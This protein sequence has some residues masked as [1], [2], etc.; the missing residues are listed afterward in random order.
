MTQSHWLTILIVFPFFSGCF[1]LFVPN[2]NNKT[3][4]WYAL[5]VSLVEFLLIIYTFCIHFDFSNPNL[6]LIEN[7]QWINKISFHWCLGVDG[8]S[9][10]LILLTGFITTLSILGSWPI[11]RN[12]RLFFF[13]ML[14]LYSGQIGVFAS[15]DLLLFFLMWEIELLPIYFLL[16]LWG[17]QKRLYAANKFIFY[18][19]LGSIFILIGA[20]IMSFYSPEGTFNMNLLSQNNYPLKLEIFIYILFFIA[21]AVKLPAFPFHTWLP[22]THGEAHSTTCMLL[23]G[24]LL[25]MGGY[26]FI[27]INMELLPNAH[28]IFAPFLIIIGIINIIYAALISFAQKNLKRK[29]AYSSVSHMGFILIGIGSL[30][31]FGLNGVILQMISHGLI[32]AA[33]FFLIG[34]VSD[35]TKTLMTENLGGLGPKMPK[36][37]TFFSI[38][39]LASLALPGMSG[40]ISELLIFIGFLN[41]SFYS[42]SFRF[43]FT[44]FEAFGILL[45]PIYLISIIRQ[46]FYGV[47]PIGFLKTY[48]FFD[49]GAR[50]IFILACLVIPILEIGFYPKSISQVYTN[51]TNSI[52]TSYL[53]K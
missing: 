32:G 51:K 31:E 3:I 42:L 13:L 49:I 25:K 12:P 23:A 28:K 11:E 44:I 20:L 22:D 38:C 14:T 46:V 39:C 21:Y 48:K 15:Q 40:F 30:T 16:L 4:H 24:I 41:S 35:R 18:T 6:Q 17:S 34:I 9:E 43:I 37:Y 36:T 26:A 2:T 1:L 5:G 52:I 10:P 8:I 7:Y 27:R 53:R 47:Q 45:T 29:I 33:L 19:A 50:E